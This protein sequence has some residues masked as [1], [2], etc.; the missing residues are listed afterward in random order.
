MTSRIPSKQ[1][2]AALSIKIMDC[3]SSLSVG[4]LVRHSDSLDGT[5]VGVT[6]NTDVTA[7]VGRVRSK[8]TSTTAEILFSGLLTGLSLARGRIHLST[9]GTLTVSKAITTGYVQ[10]LGYS[11]GDGTANFSPNLTRIKLT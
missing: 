8:P 2:G 11:F 7:V 9:S 10:V 1:L 4:D 5:V 3:D 6:T